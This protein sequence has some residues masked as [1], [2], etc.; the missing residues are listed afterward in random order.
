[1]TPLNDRKT[2]LDLLVRLGYPAILVTG[3][4]LGALSHTLTALFA[5]R[6]SGVPVR[7]IVV[8]ES[9]DSVGL[10]DTMESLNALAGTNIA[11]YGIPRLAGDDQRKWQEAPLLT[12]L[13][14]LDMTPTHP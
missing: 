1:M 6:A 11:L 3:T 7:G 4:Y 10:A 5:L 8:S 9:I 2:N 14:D 13:C 12:G